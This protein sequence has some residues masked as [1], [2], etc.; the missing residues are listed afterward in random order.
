MDDWQTKHRAVCFI[1]HL[2]RLTRKLWKLSDL[3][4]KQVSTFKARL[5]NC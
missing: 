2:P 3:L 4:M 1:P 5:D